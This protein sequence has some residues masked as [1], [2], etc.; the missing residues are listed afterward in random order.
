[1]VLELYMHLH[2]VFGIHLPLFL[3]RLADRVLHTLSSYTLLMTMLRYINMY[4]H[5][6]KFLEHLFVHCGICYTCI[7]TPGSSFTDIWHD[8][9]SAYIH[10]FCW[11]LNRWYI[12]KEY[13]YFSQYVYYSRNLDRTVNQAI[14]LI[15][16]VD[17][18]S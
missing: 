5:I 10:V 14:S 3:F 6:Y 2:N 8:S 1:M 17:T 7:P 11:T 16:V 9:L 12:V 4:A 18:V 13:L 15:N